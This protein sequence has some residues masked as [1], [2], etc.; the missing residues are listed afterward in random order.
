MDEDEE[1]RR[2][3]EPEPVRVLVIGEDP[4]AR[5]GLE[6][7]LR[8]REEIASIGE[9]AGLDELEEA[10]RAH[11]PDVIVW[12]AGLTSEP[13]VERAREVVGHGVPTIVLAD[14]AAQAPELIGAGVR[15]LLLRDVD[16]EQLAAAIRSAAAGLVVIDAAIAPSALR[17][18][19]S[20]SEALV[21]PLTPRERQVLQLLSE[22]L[23]NQAIAERLRISEHTA[24]FHVNAILGKLGA[25]NRAEAVAQG[26]RL[27]LVVL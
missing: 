11:D 22:G 27:G 6:L 25:A 23:S 14:R 13:T 19:S 8:G 7:L 24:K 15:G 18:V 4:L 20:S 1:G 3:H 21:E 16:P 2:Q 10:I 26:V 5:S 12:D 17:R 9:A